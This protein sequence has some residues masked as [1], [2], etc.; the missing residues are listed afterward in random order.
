MR[1]ISDRYF[2]NVNGV[3]MIIFQILI[4]MLAI[5]ALIRSNTA[6]RENRQTLPCYSVHID[7][8]LACFMILAI[9]IVRIK[10]VTSF[11][12]AVYVMDK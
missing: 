7:L 2:G 6:R 10:D 8:Y 1:Y 12:N 11:D 4:K 9:I 3:S 5:N